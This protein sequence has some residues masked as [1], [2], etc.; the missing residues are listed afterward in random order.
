MKAIAVTA[1]GKVEIVT[2]VP[3][4]VCGDYEALVEVYYCGFCNGTDFQ[5]INQTM[6]PEEGLMDFPTIL[7]HEG[8]GIVVEIGRKVRHIKVGDHVIHQN[9]HRD[10]GNGYTKTFGGMAEYGLI[11][12]N[13][14]M[15]EDG[16][17]AA[18]F[19]FN[20]QAV[21][22]NDLDLQDAAVMQPM[23][24]SYSAVKNFGVDE[25]KKVM[26]YGAGPMGIAV[27]KY[28]KV[29]GC[30]DLTIVDMDPTRLELAKEI[31][32]ADRLINTSEHKLKDVLGDELF[33]MVIDI[34]GHTSILIEGSGFVKPYGK[35]CSMGVLKKDD[36]L[37][38]M[39]KIKNNT[40]VHMLNFP[41]GEYDCL[42]QNI[43]LIRRGIIKP[44]QFYSHVLPMDEVHQAM[45]LVRTKRT[46]KVVLK[47]KE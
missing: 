22:P 42:E 23:C 17:T 47:I 9:L 12:D 35:V 38:D 2:D 37:L 19:P 30:P 15:L 5:V 31:T 44:K 3:R 26:I 27:A 13:Q 46:L 4:P 39:S 8:S 6:T 21:I 28:C 11:N 10:V 41:F 45:E 33:D 43:D 14:A 34:V 25:S 18:S 20:R 16:L 40:M 32:G 29:F 24:E 36:F 1:P 7:G